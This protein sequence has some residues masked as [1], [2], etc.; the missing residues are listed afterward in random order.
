MDKEVI[1]TNECDY[2][3]DYTSLGTTIDSQIN[4]VLE[5]IETSEC[6]DGI[7]Y[8]S[9]DPLFDDYVSSTSGVHNLNV[10][11]TSGVHRLSTENMAQ[12]AR[13]SQDFSV[14]MCEKVL[15]SLRCDPGKKG[16]H[17]GRGTQPGVNCI[18]L[19]GYSFGKF[20]G[21]CKRTVAYPETTQY[22]NGFMARQAPGQ[23]WS[24][25]QVSYDTSALPHRD[26]HNLKLSN[27]IVYGLGDYKGGALW[28]CGEPSGQQQPV[29]RLLPDGSKPKGYLL[30]TFQQVAIFSPSSWHA[31]QKW[32]GRRIIISAY[33]T[34]MLPH[35][36]RSDSKILRNLRF[37]LPDL[38]K[39]ALT[40]MVAE[41]REPAEP[42]LLP[43]PAVVQTQQPEDLP[44]GV[45]QH[46]MEQWRA[47]VAKLHRSA[48]HPTNRNL[49]RIIEEAGHP[50]WKV[51]VAK[52]FQCPTC[53]SLKPGGTSSGQ[54]PP[55]SLHRQY[56][57]WEAVAIDAGEWI[58]PNSKKKINFL[59][60]MDVATKLRVIQPLETYDFLQRRSE[61]AD[62]LMKS[63]SER[64]LGIFPKP[65]VLLFDS[66]RSFASEKIQD[67]ASDLNILIHYIAEKESWAH[68]TIEAAVQDVKLTA[69]AIHLESRDQPLDVTLQLAVSALNST[70]YTAGFSA[71]QWAYGRNFNISD[72]DHVTF[73][74][75]DPR[76]DFVQLVTARQK[77]EDIARSTRAKRAL[78][79]LSNTTEE[80][81]SAKFYRT[82]NMAMI[83][84]T[85]S[86]FWLDDNFYD[87]PKILEPGNLSLISYPRESTMTSWIKLPMKKKLN[88]HSYPISRTAQQQLSL[89]DDWFERQPFDL[90]NIRLIL[91]KIDYNMK[92]K[93]A[94]EFEYDLHW[95]E[96]LEDGAA[97]EEGC[98]NIFEV[99]E[100]VN[101]FLRVEIDLEPITSNRQ[102]KMLMRNPVAYMVKK[103]R[104]S[105]VVISRL[106]AH[107]RALFER[108]KAKEVDSFLKNEAVRKCLSSEEIKQ[109]YDSQRIVRAR[110]V[111]TWKLVPTDEQQQA[112]ND[113]K[114]NPNTMHDRQ[115]RR[116][117]KARI[118]L[119]GFQHPSLLDPTFK[120]ASPVQS[121]LGRNLLYLL[122]AQRQWSL[123]GLD[124]A[125]AFLQTNPTA[126]DECLWTT[127]VQELRDALGVEEEGIMRILRNI[128][129]ST[130]APRGLWLDLHKTLTRLGAIA[131][132]GERCLWVWFSKTERDHLGYKKL[133]GAMGG[134]VDDFHRVGD[135]ASP[136]WLEIK[137]AVDS[138][139]KW[140]MAKSGSYRHAGTDVTTEK[141]NDGTQKIVV[142]QSY[143]IEGLQ[144]VDITPE[145]LQGGDDVRMNTKD[146]A[147]CRA[148][149]GALQW[150]AVQSQPQLCSRCNLLLTETVTSGTLSVAKEIQMM[151]NEVRRESFKLQFF[152]LKHVKHW[153][154]VVFISMGDQAHN[155][156]P[157]GDSTG[158]M[159][160]MAAGPESLQGVV[161]PMALLAWRTWKLKRKAIGSNDAEVQSILEAEDQNFRVRMLW[162]ELNGG[163]ADKPLRVDLVD[164]IEKQITQV[165][166]VLCTDSRGGYDAVEVNESPLLGL[167]NMRSAL[168]AFQLRDNL[169]RTNSELRWVNSEYDLADGLTKK[170][171]DSRIGLLKFLQT[172]H[173]SIAFDPSFTSAKKSKKAGRTAVGRVEQFVRQHGE[174][175]D[176][177]EPFLGLMQQVWDFVLSAN[178]MQSLRPL[179]P[180]DRGPFSCEPLD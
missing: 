102:K 146:V 8:L 19:G 100:D 164:T 46:E 125:T 82:K 133:L 156:R 132:L 94:E 45:S 52:E 56:K 122:A 51:K 126:A 151:I 127:G 62:D 71:F 88:Y 76:T 72:E 134:H 5:V 176:M 49:A 33:T 171:P 147:A 84:V 66:A 18:L 3:I 143:Y 174:S 172:W 162:T 63:L 101:E 141:A 65:R 47:K 160:T 41:V 37:P 180:E 30:P 154:E 135:N 12:A 170:R 43:A 119:L 78:T 23:T 177:A 4:D 14:E 168:Q 42:P 112:L 149:L 179:S 48:G 73:Q 79:K 13:R 54:V 104:D 129:G 1:E 28:V 115:G 24:S 40:A 89:G 17:H 69:S 114:E 55:A 105:E 2:G 16:Y 64:W 60:F 97:A 131:I 61:S 75:V 59:L 39:Y 31:T 178:Q 20:H 80:L 99:M 169:K 142:D 155:N 153:S 6:D 111:L 44:D 92:T 117:A 21:V 26:V 27:N 15:L 11:S 58:P 118:V 57:A 70:E 106:P 130:T 103:M 50:L 159:V 86:G 113:A 32:T 83:D 98:G 85:S 22:L 123:E 138:A 167:S 95:V 81:F 150:L 53:Q 93:I 91:Y 7:D 10:S 36:T 68:G 145:R 136:E 25:L 148:A 29:R 87:A 158:G 109:A 116:K 124:L 165:R 139:Y 90:E 166:G 137:K 175:S 9:G 173:W 152:K 96:E 34:R 67:F 110:W 74:Q 77:A 35:F 38:G 128:Y 121:V 144:D 163:Y 157:K 161:C 107:E 108:A 140:G 120:T